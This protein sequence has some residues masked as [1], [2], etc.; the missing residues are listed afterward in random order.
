MWRHS[1]RCQMMMT[2]TLRNRSWGGDGGEG[3]GAAI[4]VVARAC[5]LKQWR[6]PAQRVTRH[7]EWRDATCTC[8][9][10]HTRAHTSTATASTL[11]KSPFSEMQRC[12]PS[13]KRVVFVRTSQHAWRLGD[14]LSARVVSVLLRAARCGVA[15]VVSASVATQIWRL[16]AAR[17]PSW[18]RKLPQP[19]SPA[20]R[21][22]MCVSV[23]DQMAAATSERST[24]SWE[25]LPATDARATGRSRW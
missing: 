18:S 20:C 13:Q 25:S 9:A 3:G 5:R 24:S 15:R 14:T 10:T 23:D 16:S 12:P 8:D 2:P 21:H 7:E 19:T 1:S 22:T 17:L 6:H 11:P 4:G